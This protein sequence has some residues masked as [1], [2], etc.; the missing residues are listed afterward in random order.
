MSYKS[1]K[2]IKQKI[3]KLWENTESIIHNI[4]NLEV[5]NDDI[6]SPD[7]LNLRKFHK[8]LNNH[9]L[10]DSGWLAS[11]F[12]AEIPGIEQ[13]G[14]I[15][16]T[17]SNGLNFADSIGYLHVFDLNIP[18]NF[19]PYIEIQVLTTIVLFWNIIIAALGR[20]TC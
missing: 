14:V 10:Y 17:N 19:L 3:S 13:D 9:T 5:I 2:N 1:F 7:E 16:T 20:E 18:K 6:L 12:D 8:L 4:S 15:F 11:H